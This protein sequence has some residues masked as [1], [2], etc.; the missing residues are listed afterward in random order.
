MGAT[1]GLRTFFSEPRCG[2][3]QFMRGRL[4]F[5][6]RY[7]RLTV[8]RRRLSVEAGYKWDSE[9]KYRNKLDYSS[10]YWDEIGKLGFIPVTG[11]ARGRRRPYWLEVYPADGGYSETACGSGFFRGRWWIIALAIRIYSRG[12]VRLDLSTL[13]PDRLRW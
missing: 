1:A 9:R 5:R 10:W 8:D 7:M 12:R 11:S 6:T 13:H 3:P 2:Y 4:R